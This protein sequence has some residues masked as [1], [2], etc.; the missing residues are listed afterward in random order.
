MIRLW[1]YLT[2]LMRDVLGPPLRTVLAPVDSW[3]SGLP[4]WVGQACAVTLFVL[5]GL[6]LLTVRR[7]YVYLGAPDRA[8]WRDLRIWAAVALLPYVVLYVVFK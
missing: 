5:A 1:E 8:A 4:L 6:W 3:L 2:T 7:D